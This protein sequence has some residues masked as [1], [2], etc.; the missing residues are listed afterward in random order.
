M[1]PKVLNYYR[2]INS[3]VFPADTIYIGR[4][5]PWGNPFVIGKDGTR[6]EV[7][8]KYKNWFL[9]QN[10][11][12]TPLTGKNLVCYCSPKACHGDFLLQEANKSKT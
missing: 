10:I 7:I 9:S 3:A 11:D 6:E 1:S 5:S 12:L 4:G 8:E 2:D